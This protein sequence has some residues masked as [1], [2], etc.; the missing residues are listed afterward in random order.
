MGRGQSYGQKEPESEPG[1]ASDPTVQ[2][3]RAQDPVQDA[4]KGQ[5]PDQSTAKT[6]TRHGATNDKAKVMAAETTDTDT[7]E[8]NLQ[9]QA[10][11]SG[12]VEKQACC[13]ARTTNST[14]TAAKTPPPIFS[15]PAPIKPLPGNY[16]DTEDFNVVRKSAR[17][18]TAKRVNKYGG[19]NYN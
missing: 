12:D 4:N 15:V 5:N 9:A 7:A 8:V 19:V 14:V 17:L 3:D 6:T 2:G 16:A 13:D 11:G 18:P 10:S 1:L